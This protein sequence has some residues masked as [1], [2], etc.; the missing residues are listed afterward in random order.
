MVILLGLG[1]IKR[2][3]GAKVF[4]GQEG[5]GFL[6]SLIPCLFLLLLIPV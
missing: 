4:L 6:I 3:V 1:D 5:L 2:K